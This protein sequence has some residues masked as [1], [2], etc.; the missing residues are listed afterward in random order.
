MF[1]A[2]PFKS[3]SY[4]P[5]IVVMGPDDSARLFANVTGVCWNEPWTRAVAITNHGPGPLEF[6][7]T[8]SS[9]GGPPCAAWTDRRDSLQAFIFGEGR[10]IYNGPVAS[11]VGVNARVQIP[12][13]GVATLLFT[14]FVPHRTENQ[15]PSP[16]Q[17][18]G[19]TLIPDT[20]RSRTEM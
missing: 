17:G 7:I 14:F 6:A 19:V 3:N 12:Q 18:I 9:Q 16:V 5:A 20:A 10:I 13:G 1:H 2:V 4:A 15:M 11:L 8:A